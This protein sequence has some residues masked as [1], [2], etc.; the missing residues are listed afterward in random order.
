MTLINN[1]TK[2]AKSVGDG[3]ASMAN[4]VA[5]RSGELV[6]IS[7]LTLNVATLEDSKKDLFKGIGQTIF[8]QFEAGSEFTEVV[9]E[10]C[11]KV[12]ET[13]EKINVI[14]EKIMELK[15]IN[16]CLSCGTNMKIED[17]F[18]SKCGAK[19]PEIEIVEEASNEEQNDEIAFE[20][21]VTDSDH[22]VCGP[23]NCD[24]EL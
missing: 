22:E 5:K 19:L 23:L 15:N 24:K 20:T 2:I 14:K 6:E 13:D 21:P 18:C 17:K 11:A 10:E 1:I 4:S 8:D 7:K 12:K 16:K 3:A 9:K